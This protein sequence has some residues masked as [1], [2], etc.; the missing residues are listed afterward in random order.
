MGE[1]RFQAAGDLLRPKY[2]TVLVGVQMGPQ[3]G[4]SLKTLGDSF[5]AQRELPLCVWFRDPCL[6]EPEGLCNSEAPWYRTPFTMAAQTT[7][8]PRDGDHSIFW[9]TLHQW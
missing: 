2:C 7:C 1:L 5:N 3:P 9:D 4:T 6:N 8:F